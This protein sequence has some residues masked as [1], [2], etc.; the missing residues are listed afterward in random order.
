MAKKLSNLSKAILE[1]ASD[2]FRTGLMDK[3]ECE[4]I[5]VRLFGAQSLPAAEPISSKV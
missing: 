3:A 5:T 4:K 1:M 2:Q